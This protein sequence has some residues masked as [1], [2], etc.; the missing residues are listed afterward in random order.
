[1][2]DARR[3]LIA[4]VRV[5]AQMR[6]EHL[7]YLVLAHAQDRDWG[8]HRG[9]GGSGTGSR[10]FLNGQGRIGLGGK[11]RRAARFDGTRHKRAD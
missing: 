2:G 3:P 9:C 6:A 5:A 1:M 4:N 8:W 10:R 7:A 11:R